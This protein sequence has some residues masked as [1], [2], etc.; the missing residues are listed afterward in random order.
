MRADLW[1]RC[2]SVEPILATPG[3]R[4]PLAASAAPVI[5]V[6]PI[7]GGRAIKGPT[8][9]IM[10]DLGMT[11][12]AAA[13]AKR[14][15]DLLGGYVMDVGDA[16][17]AA[18]LAPRVTLAPTVMTNLAE[19]EEQAPRGGGRACLSETRSG[20]RGVSGPSRRSRN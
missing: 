13:V 15:G 14:Y 17:Q 5:A 3:M 12:S 1:N 7:I 8:A 19:R 18:H 4:Q 16:E 6:S 10:V 2:T 20:L 11:P 9:K